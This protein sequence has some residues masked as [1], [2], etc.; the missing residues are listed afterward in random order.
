MA[1]NQL[2]ANHTCNYQLLRLHTP[3]GILTYFAWVGISLVSS[4][5]I[6]PVTLQIITRGQLLTQLATFDV[7]TADRV[8]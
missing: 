8:S 2:R 4:Q 6:F 1:S 3:W 7:R 5:V